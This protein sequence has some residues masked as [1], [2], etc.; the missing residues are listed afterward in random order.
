MKILDLLDDDA[1]H[2]LFVAML[3]AIIA[4]VASAGC[5]LLLINGAHDIVLREHYRWY[6]FLLPVSVVVFLSAKRFASLK[7]ANVTEQ[8]L[9]AQILLIAERLRQAEL[10][11]IEQLS[12][13]RIYASL[14]DAY[15]ISNLAA[16]S[17]TVIW[18]SVA[19]LLCWLALFSHGA[20]VG[21]LFLIG[22]FGM[23]A[24]GEVYG[25]LFAD[26]SQEEE[27]QEE[28]M[29]RIAHHLLNGYKELAMRRRQSDD[30]FERYL[31]PAISRI[32]VLGQKSGVYFAGLT[33]FGDTIYF[34]GLGMLVFLLSA[35]YPQEATLSL[36]TILLYVWP[37]VFV[38]L[39]DVPEI[40]EGAAAMERLAEFADTL[41]PSGVVAETP[42]IPSKIRV[43]TLQ[44]VEFHYP[45]FDAAS[46]FSIGPI[47]LEIQAGEILFL[48]G[49]NGSGKSTLLKVLAGLYPASSGQICVNEQPLQGQQLRHLFAGVLQH[50]HLFDSVYGIAPVDGRR[51]NALLLQMDLR[52]HTQW[53]DGRF[54]SLRLS[55]GQ[56]RR[57]ALVVALME[58]KPLYVFDE[59][60]ADQAP[61]FRRYFYEELLP[62]LKQQGK[63]IIAVT[64]DDHYYH[65][66]DRVI[67]M[68]YG[69]IVHEEHA[70][71]RKE[72]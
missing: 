60:A 6:L 69:A 48:A 12:A 67:R 39:R 8:F 17:V 33:T 68:E 35:W 66:A 62:D 15:T 24:I 13:S 18:C 56:Q 9:S 46:A 31:T 52:Q 71:E 25:K 49:G 23:Y 21:L 40:A 41:Q 5:A 42:A 34:I 51:L 44:D 11:H 55:A 4:G 37:M 30:L 19:I 29:F 7:I 54:T 57:L 65:L 70:V 58:D 63:T 22:V 38:L 2:A 64:H 43:L 61:E 14:A 27:E 32:E 45:A 53:K 3:L 47:S 59:W 36:L 50:F 1:R 28:E 10:I 20:F 26:A 16:K 72:K